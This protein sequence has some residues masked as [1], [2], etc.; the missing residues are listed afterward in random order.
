MTTLSMTRS[1]QA[2]AVLVV[3]L[4]VFYVIAQSW[5]FFLVVSTDILFILISGA[6]SALALLVVL[7]ASKKGQTALPH[8]AAKLRPVHVGLFLS[9]SLWFL[10]E[11]TWGIYE[12]VLRIEVP[13]PSVAE[14]FYLAGYV[15]VLLSIFRFMWL[16]KKLITPAKAAASGFTGLIILGLTT[17]FVL[18]PLYNSPTDFITKGFDLAYPIL[19]AVVVVLVAMRFITFASTRI[20]KPW[21]W[22]FSGLFLQSIADILFSYGTLTGWYYSGHPIELLWLFGYLSLMLG[23][24]GQRKEF[25]DKN[26]SQPI[27]IGQA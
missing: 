20:G 6:T 2:V 26:V 24:N 9:V 22:I 3:L 21:L 10:G 23:F 19:D 13:Y 11:L 27:I 8:L 5:G 16:F 18:E 14:I 1:T 4:A 7:Q 17:V 25:S 12:I 15:P